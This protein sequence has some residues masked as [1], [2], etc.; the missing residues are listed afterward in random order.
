MASEMALTDRKTKPQSS[1][2]VEV[3]TSTGNPLIV[4]QGVV[5]Q[6]KNEAINMAKQSLV[7]T[8]E[9]CK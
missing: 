6:T 3:E 5:A 7:F 2:D 8:A 4:F 9:R 1:F